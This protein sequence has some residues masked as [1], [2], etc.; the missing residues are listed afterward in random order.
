MVKLFWKCFYNLLQTHVDN[1]IKL[2]PWYQFIQGYSDHDCTHFSP[3]IYDVKQKD[4]K[5]KNPWLLSHILPAP[6][7]H[8]CGESNLE[9]SKFIANFSSCVTHVLNNFFFD[10]YSRFG[11][12]F[13]FHS[14]MVGE[15]SNRLNEWMEARKIEISFYLVSFIHYVSVKKWNRKT[16]LFKR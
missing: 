14:C 15:R 2:L 10:S 3:P 16:F 6:N 5:L 1:E 7:Q 11:C 12:K 4:G 8:S 13:P 9:M